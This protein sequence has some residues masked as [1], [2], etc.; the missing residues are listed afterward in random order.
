M[1]IS[2]LLSLVDG[3]ICEGSYSDVEIS[4]V[5]YNSRMALPGSLF[6]AVEGLVTDGHSYIGAAY[7]NGCRAFL[8]RKNFEGAQMLAGAVFLRSDDT[9]K[10][11]SRVSAAFYGD[12]SAKIPVIGITG[13]NGKT[14][15]TYMIEAILREAGRRPGVIGTVNYRWGDT[16]LAAPNTTP[17]SRDIH[18]IMGRMYGEGVDVIVMEVSSHGL[19]LGRVDDINFALAA[20]TNLTRDHLDYHKTFDEYFAAK[21]R[22]FSLLSDSYP[23]EAPKYALLNID[24][25]YGRRL[26]QSL[27][28]DFTVY[29]LSAALAA[30]YAIDPDS[31]HMRL[32][33]ISFR[34]NEGAG[35][36]DVSMK[37][38]A[39]FSMYNAL[40]A[41]ACCRCL[42][43][44]PQHCRAGLQ[45]IETVPGRFST[46]ASPKGFYVVV[47]YAHTDDAL[48]KLL[49]SARELNPSKLITVFGCGGDRDKSK[50]P[51]MGKSALSFSDFAV[52]TSDNPRT[53]NPLSIID[54]I[55][56]GIDAPAE[57]Y[58]VIP[59]REEAI[60]HAV[61]LAQKGDLV[62]IAGK[63][64]EDYQILG[65]TKI[66]FDDREVAAKYMGIQL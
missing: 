34:V 21:K 16:V 49:S 25:E 13:T 53:E 65:K 18:A 66:H 40:C 8:V 64:H 2:E 42:A 4:D 55:L 3:L 15:T 43:V 14:S 60:A 33:G 22:L 31:V 45:K 20:F 62:V 26:Q 61:A 48:V 56:S 23:P 51:L 58:T 17:E 1:L 63:G 46:M 47:D 28:G 27:K 11:L 50:R 52:V 12:V 39:R 10:D 6:V 57:K 29:S 44:A 36:F 59:D 35:S 30:D 54:D 9:R 19:A 24:D 7:E 41:W 32:D 5:V 38:T 37:M